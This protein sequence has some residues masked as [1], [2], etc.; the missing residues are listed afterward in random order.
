ME[1][2]SRVC[3]A[4][5]LAVVVGTP[6]QMLKA[7]PS[8]TY[9]PSSVPPVK[10]GA[11]RLVAS[12]LAKFEYIQEWPQRSGWPF[13]D[14]ENVGVRSP[15][16]RYIATVLLKGDPVEGLLSG[17]LL[18]VDTSLPFDKISVRVLAELKSADH[19]P[20]KNLTWTA[21]SSAVYFIGSS[22]TEQP[23][24]YKVGIADGKARAVTSGP[25]PVVDFRLD[26]GETNLL[27]STEIF[28]AFRQR[29]CAPV[30][31]RIAPGAVFSL[32]GDEK[33]FVRLEMHDLA[34]GKVL[35][36]KEPTGAARRAKGW[37]C[38]NTYPRSSPMS[39]G[40]DFI[41]LACAVSIDR[42]LWWGKY[43]EGS[44]VPENLRQDAPLANS[45][46]FVIGRDG[47]AKEL[48]IGPYSQYSAPWQWIGGH[49]FV[50]VGAVESI[51]EVQP[52]ELVTK[53]SSRAILLVDARTGSVTRIA[54]FPTDAVVTAISWDDADRALSIASVDK[55]LIPHPQIKLVQRGTKWVR[56]QEQ[57]VARKE[58]IRLR[59][60]D[61][62]NAPAE[63]VLTDVVDNKQRVLLKLNQWL[64]DYELGRVEEVKWR[65][66]T[67]QVWQGGLY[68]PP[69]YT[70]GVRYPLLI[71]TRGYA[72]GRHNLQGIT[73][74]FPGQAL[75]ARGVVVLQ[76]GERLS[77]GA[78][79]TPR[80]WVEV[81]KGYE[82]A[83]DY[84]ASRNLIDRNRVGLIGWSRSAPYIGFTI[85]HS[86][87]PFAA[88]AMTGGADFGWYWNILAGAPSSLHQ[89]YGGDPIGPGVEH[90]LEHSTT[91]N[92]D[93]F[94]AP[95]FL[96]S[97]ESI[98]STWDLFAG[99]SSIG[100]PVER[101]ASKG[102]DH[103]GTSV[104]HQVRLNELLVDWFDFWLNSRE[105]PDPAKHEQYGRWRELKRLHDERLRKPKRPLLDWKAVPLSSRADTK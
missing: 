74:L 89:I 27:T 90:W 65:T 9:S 96:W 69:G 48:K 2:M 15:D 86:N 66:P 82:S 50:L 91:F 101:W 85:T 47:G 98:V 52:P 28:E 12:D 76:V 16:G 6:F 24:V 39:P 7:A 64:R 56:V 75:A 94:Y 97:G 79:Q 73:R 42:P 3:T 70:A 22:G 17:R 53:A 83:V 11:R 68:L 55:W 31:C 32:L 29:E 67:G 41:L 77:P 78:S 44:G 54:E 104:R 61:S 103:W 49:H 25:H 71:Q 80:E 88:A 26:S 10:E 87:Y 63:L 84:L 72:T 59:L 95:L 34:S 57:E 20:I 60:I 100:A 62:P 19:I 46:L 18:L 43:R 40:G 5:L 102:G 36:I 58:R 38:S 81:Q 37:P 93:R 14:L 92:L 45:T 51:E 23:K 13:L 1:I 35:E 33:S 105:D 21:G 99:L 30:A 8:E 4:A